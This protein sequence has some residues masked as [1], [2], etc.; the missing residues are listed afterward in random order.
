M[1]TD[2]VTKCDHVV[3]EGASYVF[4]ILFISRFS[5]GILQ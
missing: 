1:T 4:M 2:L 5:V 3:P